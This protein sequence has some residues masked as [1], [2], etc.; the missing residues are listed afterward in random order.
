MGAVLRWQIVAG[1]GGVE[2]EFQLHIGVAPALPGPCCFK[3]LC[4]QWRSQ[5]SIFCCCEGHT[6]RG[7]TTSAEAAA[8]SAAESGKAATLRDFVRAAAR[9]ESRAVLVPATAADAA[10][11]AWK[12]GRLSLSA[13]LK[14]LI[15]FV[16]GFHKHLNFCGAAFNRV[17]PLVAAF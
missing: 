9:A 13:S 12:A 5:F 7:V 14:L 4:H 10:E 3:S 6:A 17:R 11:D 8:E 15:E 2:D 16:P 1:V